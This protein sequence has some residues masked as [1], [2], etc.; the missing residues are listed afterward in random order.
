MIKILIVDDHQMVRI[1]LETALSIIDDFEV[2]GEAKNGQLAVT[3]CE[4]NS[5]DVILMDLMMPVMDGITA[6]KKIK[7]EYPD[8]RIIALT[9]FPE[10]DLV[11]KAIEAGADSYL[12]KDVTV[13]RLEEAIRAASHGVPT[14]SPE[15]TRVL[16]NSRRD[17]NRLGDDLTP[18]ETEVLKIMVSGLNNR[19]IGEKLFISRAT[20]SVHVSKILSK[21]NV[22]NRVEAVTLAI[23]LKLLK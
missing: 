9:S 12:L 14:L 13:H 6:I 20:V 23:S 18:R 15:A 21:L 17:S 8:I 11:E 3:F 1:G 2:C 16:L 10:D 22:S 19:Q 4:K 7:N 5:V